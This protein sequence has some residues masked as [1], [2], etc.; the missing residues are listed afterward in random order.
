M[1]STGEVMGSADSFGMAYAKAELGAG[2]ALP[3]AGTVFLQPMTGTNR[4]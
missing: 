4:H 2:E 1:R 3:T